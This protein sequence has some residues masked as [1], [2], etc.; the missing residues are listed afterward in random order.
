MIGDSGFANAG[1]G[2]DERV[3]LAEVEEGKIGLGVA[4]PGEA[5]GNVVLG[6]TKDFLLP[7]VVLAVYVWEERD[8]FTPIES[9][10]KAQVKAQSFADT[11]D[12]ELRAGDRPRR[13][14]PMADNSR[15]RGLKNQKK[16]RQR[17]A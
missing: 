5:A 3:F 10:A 16:S 2:V 12:P 13:L 7:F 11:A 14:P 6:E 15:L 9:G 4:V 17:C 8:F 1:K